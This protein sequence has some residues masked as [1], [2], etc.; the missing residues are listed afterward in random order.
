MWHVVI[1]KNAFGTILTVIRAFRFI[2][3]VVLV[4]GLW[5]KLLEEIDQELCY[6][7]RFIASNTRQYLMLLPHVT[8]I[9]TQS[10]K[11]PKVDLIK[12]VKGTVENLRNQFENFINIIEFHVA[13]VRFSIF[14]HFNFNFSLLRHFSFQFSVFKHFNFPY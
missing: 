14:R 5:T 12:Y 2:I 9:F 3:L 6:W 13:N 1:F 8:V 11:F 10:D 4:L 7:L